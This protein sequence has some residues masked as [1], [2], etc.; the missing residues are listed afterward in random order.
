MGSVPKRWIAE[1]SY[2]ADWSVDA[3]DVFFSED[4][5]GLSAVLVSAVFFEVA[6]LGAGL[7]A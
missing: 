7:L 4:D 5:F 6:L 1:L 3:L 2:G